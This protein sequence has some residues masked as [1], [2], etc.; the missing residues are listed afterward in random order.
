MIECTVSSFTCFAENISDDDD[1][2]LKLVGFM[3]SLPRGVSFTVQA[4]IHTAIKRCTGE[5]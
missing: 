1:M 3:E 5:I 2:T 4:H